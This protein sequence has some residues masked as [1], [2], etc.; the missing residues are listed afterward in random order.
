MKVFRKK[1][2]APVSAKRPTVPE[3]IDRL[4]F[5]LA[6]V[7]AVLL[8][9][10]VWLADGA[11]LLLIST[12]TRAVSEEWGLTAYERGMVVTMV[13]V[14]IL[15]GNMASGPLGDTFGRK[16]LIIASYVGIFIFS[17]LSSYSS[18]FYA[19]ACIRLFVGAAFGIGQPAWT[20][21]SSE[22]TPSRWRIAANSA[23]MSLFTIGEVYSGLIIFFED[24]EME[25]LDWR[26]L[27]RIGAAPS[28]VC[29]VLAYFFLHQS[30]LYLALHGKP[31]EAREVL[32]S[33]RRQNGEDASTDFE[34]PEE[35]SQSVTFWEKVNKQVSIVLGDHLLVSTLI[36]IYTCFM[37]NLCF[38]GCLYAFPQVLPNLEMASSPAVQL[39][40]GAA[41]EVPGLAVGLA[42]GLTMSRKLAMH[43][44]GLS[45]LSAL[46][47][48][49]FGIHGDPTGFWSQVAL[50]YGYYGIKA[51]VMIG[52]IVVYQYASEIYPTEA[53]ITGT[54]VNIAGGRL[55][56]IIAPLLF[57]LL[58]KHTGHFDSFFMLIAAMLSFNILLFNFLPFETANMPLSDRLHDNYGAAMEATASDK[59]GSA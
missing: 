35:V 39:L 22:V 18:S 38:Y 15:A 37:L 2:P 51:Y 6:Q 3:I 57:E 31:D 58:L 46:V 44:Y 25:V 17:I 21:L 7:R 55:A 30:P 36:I 10:G 28:L 1:E 49:V 43:I 47:A 34:P 11:E 19:L 12:V 24:P 40:I 56:G 52:F 42:V 26:W 20:A 13:F 53:R 16:Q 45:M 54:A 9:G 48:F 5:G 50:H 32:E 14:G 4:G 41:W 29:L 59:A 27:L 33:M 8:G 23:S